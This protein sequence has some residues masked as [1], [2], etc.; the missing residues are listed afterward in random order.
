M[1]DANAIAANVGRAALVDVRLAVGAI[2]AARALTVI[3]V[4]GIVT[5]GAIRTWSR[6]A[7]PIAVHAL[8]ADAFIAM[9][10]HRLLAVVRIARFQSFASLALEA[11]RTFAHHTRAVREAGAP[12]QADARLVG[13]TD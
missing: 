4:A 7:G 13:R 12:I 10:D 8:W 11:G 3:V 9:A 1:I 2:V 6:R 5:R